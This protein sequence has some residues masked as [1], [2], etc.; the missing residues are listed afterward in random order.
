MQEESMPDDVNKE[1]EA[2]AH[3]SPE[4]IW[5]AMKFSPLL[6]DKLHH[7]E[8]AQQFWRNKFQLYFPLE[9]LHQP[10]RIFPEDM[11]D[12]FRKRYLKHVNDLSQIQ[13]LL[14]GVILEGKIEYFVT[15][16]IAKYKVTVADL[17]KLFS[18]NHNQNYLV[19]SFCTD[20]MLDFIY[21]MFLLKH[22]EKL[23]GPY[24]PNVLKKIE[25]AIIFNQSVNDIL[26][27]CAD[28]KRL[29]N[30]AFICSLKYN[31]QP[32]Y[33]ELLKKCPET[34]CKDEGKWREVFYARPINFA[35]K[36]ANIDA[37]KK[38]KSC[39]VNINR[40]GAQQSI[41]YNCPLHIAA[42][43][44][45]LRLFRE[46]LALGAD[47]RALNALRKNPLSIAIEFGQLNIVKE[48]LNRRKEIKNVNPDYL[49]YVAAEYG[50]K[51]I[52]NYLI[53]V[54]HAQVTAEHVLAAALSGNV[55]HD[56]RYFEV[57]NILL[58]YNPLALAHDVDIMKA[59]NP[60]ATAWGLG[61]DNATA[62][63]IKVFRANDIMRK[64]LS[65]A[66]ACQYDE[67]VKALLNTNPSKDVLIEALRYAQ[68]KLSPSA[69]TIR[70][71]LLEM[72][73]AQ[74]LEEAK[75]NTHKSRLPFFNTPLGASIALKT[76]VATKQ[77]A[78][79]NGM[80]VEFTEEEKKALLEGELG[81][82]I[83]PLGKEH[84]TTL[85]DWLNNRFN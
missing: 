22:I 60:V 77:I 84:F 28:E 69:K 3:L 45:N 62:K 37:I 82:I 64:V 11:Y 80:K 31:R 74:N 46:L 55:T 35:A 78:Q 71:K 54:E 39:G 7:G 27:M 53:H 44:G 23:N 4:E 32:L 43:H 59:I 70:I 16:I 73:I 79:E 13:R 36:F 76:S 12:E 9:M 72:Y 50:Q 29:I 1:L 34:D 8:Y 24:Q 18:Q 20:E 85:K 5:E 40:L 56:D 10:D 17:F 42:M 51:E 67:T 15:S 38:L 21:K 25:L 66:I 48:C 63:Q 30:H 49:L 68:N 75:T 83:D 52:V 58:E 33:D 61:F 19:P 41:H 2:V 57:I 47:I 14:L 81:N 26:K 6:A 65:I